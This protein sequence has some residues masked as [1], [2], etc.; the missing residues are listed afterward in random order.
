MLPK[1]SMVRTD[2]DDCADCAI[3]EDSLQVLVEGVAV[4]AVVE[5]SAHSRKSPN[6]VAQ[7]LK[8]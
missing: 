4:L 1:E 8:H 6:R 2:I 3:L 7:W 5:C